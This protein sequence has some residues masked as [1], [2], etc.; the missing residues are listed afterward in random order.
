[1]YQSNNAMYPN[2]FTTPLCSL[3]VSCALGFS[4][5]FA[6]ETVKADELSSL[7]QKVEEKAASVSAF[8]CAF[9]Q[10]RR[11]A[12]FSKPVVFRGDLT[13]V[14][15]DRLRWEFVRP[16]PSVLIVNGTRGLR[17][18]GTADPQKFELS[19]NPV[20]RTVFE[21][22]WAWMNGE[23]RR[24]QE[25]YDITMTPPQSTGIVL[26][27]REQA[28]AGVIAEI[29]ILFDPLSLQPVH[30]EIQEVSGDTTLLDFTDYNLAPSIDEDFF[31]QCSS[32]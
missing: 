8:S 2:S 20:M 12:L 24:M 9:R 17:C 7:L 32:R 22:L 3:I 21:Q 23:Y 28:M 13:I 11:L 1:M 14:R 15:P 16:V 19:G 25:A 30:V 27:P 6:A 31:E 18:S 4:I 5:L 26:T 10:E 29:K